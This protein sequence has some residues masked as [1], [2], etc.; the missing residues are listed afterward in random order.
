MPSMDH[1]PKT[2]QLTGA[3]KALLV[4]FHYLLLPLLPASFLAASLPVFRLLQS[5]SL[6][7][8]LLLESLVESLALAQIY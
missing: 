7:F 1:E 5:F 4:L 3:F 6:S 2:E 8:L